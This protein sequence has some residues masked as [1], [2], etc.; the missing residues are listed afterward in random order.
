MSQMKNLPLCDLRTYH[1]PESI[2]AI[3]SIE[4]VALLIFPQDPPPAVQQALHSIPLQNVAAMITLAP[5]DRVQVINGI[6]EITAG[7]LASDGKTALLI[8]G[9]AVFAD[10]A[11]QAKGDIYLNGIAVIQNRLRDHPGLT[12]AM[13]NGLKLYADFAASKIHPQIATIDRDYLTWLPP[14]T[15]IIAGRLLRIQEDVTIDLLR[16]KHV[17]LLAASRYTAPTRSKVL[18]NPSPSP[19]TRSAVF[20]SSRQRPNSRSRDLERGR[21]RSVQCL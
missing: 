16:E 1:E 6:A 21:G 12:F 15:A 9:I 10:L 11:P 13:C 4:N 18:C 3:K 2:R 5:D 14:A 17:R 20:P 8:N 7:D 19:A